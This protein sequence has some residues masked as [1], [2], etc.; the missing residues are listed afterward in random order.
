MHANISEIV[1]ISKLTVKPDKGQVQIG[2]CCCARFCK[3]VE[4][5]KNHAKKCK[6]IC[7]S[8]IPFKLRNYA[9][10]KQIKAKFKWVLVVVMQ[11]LAKKEPRD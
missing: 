4:N 7:K 9:R 11:I 10:A 3:Y 8:Q 2:P 1:Q 5:L 6:V